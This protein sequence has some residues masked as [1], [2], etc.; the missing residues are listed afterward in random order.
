MAENK[1]LAD[2]DQVEASAATERFV[3][4]EEAPDLLVDGFQGLVNHNGVIKIIF[5]Q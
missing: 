2:P 4:A 1:G 5:S 3:V